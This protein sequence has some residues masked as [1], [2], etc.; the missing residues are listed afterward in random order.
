MGPRQGATLSSRSSWLVTA[1]PRGSHSA[2][3]AH[4][5]APPPLQWCESGAPGLADP[6]LAA[7]LQRPGALSAPSLSP[8]LHDADPHSQ[9]PHPCRYL[10]PEAG[11]GQSLVD[12][13]LR[14]FVREVGARS[15]APGG[16]S[17]AAASAAMVSGAGARM[18]GGRPGLGASPGLG[19]VPRTGRSP[20]GAA[21]ASMAGLMTYGR[22]QF[23][24]LDATV[25]R[26]IPPFHAAWAEL[27]AMVDADARA[28][29]AYL[30]SVQ[31]GLHHQPRRGS[32]EGGR[33]GSVDGTGSGGETSGSG[34]QGEG[35]GLPRAQVSVDAGGWREETVVWP[36]LGP[37]PQLVQGQARRVWCRRDCRSGSLQAGGGPR[38]A[39]VL[40]VSQAQ[41][42][43]A[44]VPV[45]H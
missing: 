7:W 21:L 2:Y 18:R 14:T 20:Q 22:R 6:T 44:H 32:P 41:R 12:Q 31:A 9:L 33:V 24:H 45:S 4:I 11:P 40:R 37:P 34:S 19:P 39:P 26:L 35:E 8:P 36:L 16:G 3:R 23:E 42:P 43:P 17:V 5:P 30:V 1:P 10:V 13:P 38:R 29:E 28:F 15:A 27:T 25:R